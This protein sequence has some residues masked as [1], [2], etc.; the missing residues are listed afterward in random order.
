MKIKTKYRMLVPY[1]TFF[2]ADNN[3]GLLFPSYDGWYRTPSI[4][5]HLQYYMNSLIEGIGVLSYNYD[6]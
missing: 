4:G 3:F 1:D 2:S 6:K 5:L